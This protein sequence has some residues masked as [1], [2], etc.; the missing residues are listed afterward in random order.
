MKHPSWLAV[1]A[2]AFGAALLVAF[3]KG[4]VLGVLFGAVFSPLPLAMVVL[5]LG[6]LYLPVAILSGA[7]TVTVLT[8]SFVLAAIY[9][10]IDAAPVAVLARFMRAPVESASG[11]A[12]TGTVGGGTSLGKAVA[13]ITAGAVVM[14][15]AVL[16]AMAPE[17]QAAGGIEASLRA[18]LLE[19]VAAAPLPSPAEVGG[20]DLA[21]ARTAM[22]GKIAGLLPGA[23]A[24]NWSLRVLI[25]GALG[26][27]ML[28][29][30]GLALGTT[31]AYRRFA[32]PG[33]LFLL[34]A[35]MAGAGVVLKGDPGL[36]AGNAAV[37]LCLAPVLQGLAVVH[38]ALGRLA[39]PGLAL[40]VFYV[41]ALAFSSVFLV[42][43]VAAGVMDHFFQLRER[44][45]PQTGGE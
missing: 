3:F 15:V 29:R 14:L 33:W 10:L 45:A 27:V 8:G 16:A 32:A 22:V 44:I 40:A 17:A 39:W 18:Q 36:I 42:G 34:F 30:M 23:A 2:G 24:L 1:A 26:Q 38:C 31:P 6:S 13:V 11:T 19:L 9:I 25:S 21:A 28:K 37:A 5:G 35:G 7:V 43:L 20:V 41:T 4:S 12:A